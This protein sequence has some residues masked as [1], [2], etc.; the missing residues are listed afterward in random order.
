MIKKKIRIIC[1]S[2]NSKKWSVIF[3]FEDNKRNFLNEILNIVF[4][5]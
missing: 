5:I 4:G 2:I 1:M 3:C